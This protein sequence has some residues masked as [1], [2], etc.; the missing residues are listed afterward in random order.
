MDVWSTITIISLNF[1]ISIKMKNRNTGC[2]Y[3]VMEN[4]RSSTFTHR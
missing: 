2:M 1:P 4:E 3:D